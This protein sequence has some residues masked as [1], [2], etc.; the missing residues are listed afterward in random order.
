MAL[1][2]KV[3]IKYLKKDPEAYIRFVENVHFGNECTV[4][5]TDFEYDEKRRVFILP[6][7]C[8]CY[9]EPD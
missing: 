4:S 3:L 2:A 9:P 5:I 6:N 1:K 7:L 8:M